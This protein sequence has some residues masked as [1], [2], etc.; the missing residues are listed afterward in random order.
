MRRLECKRQRCGGINPAPQPKLP[1][2][3]GRFAQHANQPARHP[4]RVRERASYTPKQVRILPAHLHLE[5]DEALLFPALA[6]NAALLVF[7][8]IGLRDAFRKF[9]RKAA[10]E[11]TGRRRRSLNQPVAVAQLDWPPIIVGKGM[12]WSTRTIP[13]RSA[14]RPR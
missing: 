10:S 2:S 5:A 8:I 14:I 13:V 1:P 6:V 11:A 9:Y 4:C 3:R 7:L 12:A